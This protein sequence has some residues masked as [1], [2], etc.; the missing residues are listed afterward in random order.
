MA[1]SV[2]FCL[3]KFEQFSRTSDIDQTAFHKILEKFK[4]KKKKCL[5]ELR[6]THLKDYFN[7][8][9]SF[10][11]IFYFLCLGFNIPGCFQILKSFWDFKIHEYA[12]RELTQTVFKYPL[13]NV[14][15]YNGTYLY[16]PKLFKNLFAFTFVIKNKTALTKEFV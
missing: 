12:A 15:I 8:F 3:I 16:R 4:K 11:F 6:I 10:F 2:C 9:Q 14:I 7:H 5:E 13:K 1:E